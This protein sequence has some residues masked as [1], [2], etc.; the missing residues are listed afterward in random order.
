MPRPV[1][2]YHLRELAD[3]LNSTAIGLLI[4]INVPSTPP[5]AYR[6]TSFDFRVEDGEDDDGLPIYFYPWPIQIGVLEQASDAS[7]PQ[8]SINIANSA[9]N[10]VAQKVDEFDG[11]ELEAVNIRLI[12]EGAIGEDSVALEENFAITGIE[13]SPQQITITCSAAP[14]YNDPLPRFRYSRVRCRKTFGSVECGYTLDIGGATL[15]DCPGYTLEACE[16]VGAEELARGITGL[17][18]RLFGG[19]RG[20]PSRRRS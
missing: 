17:H 11:L 13:V 9:G 12:A 10:E 2:T 4:Q 19:Q 1:D 7:L 5:T 18:P 8:L 20:I 3:L 15:T 16:A 14:V 6:L